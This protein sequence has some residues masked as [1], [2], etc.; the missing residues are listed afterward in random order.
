MERPY[1]FGTAHA[2][3]RPVANWLRQE[4]TVT[5]I[6]YMAEFLAYHKGWEGRTL[7]IL[8]YYLGTIMLLMVRMQSPI[9]WY[10]YTAYNLAVN[11]GDECTSS[12]NGRFIVIG[13]PI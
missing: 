5:G 2:H 6:F 4:A 13:Y 1:R 3:F 10:H 9:D 11:P 8:T 7:L 12:L